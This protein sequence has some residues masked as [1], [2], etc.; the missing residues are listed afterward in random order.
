MNKRGNYKTKQ[1]D[2]IL[3]YMKTVPGKH[4]TVEEVHA[5]LVKEGHSIGST[6]VYRHLNRMVDD[7]LLNK[8]SIDPGTPAC[9]EYIHVATPDEISGCYHCKCEVCGRL[10]HLHCEE[11][12]EF[13]AHLRNTH[14]FDMNPARTVFYGT[15]S[16][17]AGRKGVKVIR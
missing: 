4:F 9:Y 8:Y 12:A 11:I 7:G 5:A 14:G 3:A 10:I 6:T 15:C 2:I 13:Y 17:C 16:D 1:Y